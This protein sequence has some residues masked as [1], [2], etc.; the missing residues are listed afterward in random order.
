M[1]ADTDNAMTTEIFKSPSMDI[2]MTPSAEDQTPADLVITPSP[3]SAPWS[4]PHGEDGTTDTPHYHA[5]EDGPPR[6]GAQSQ[7]KYESKD[8]SQT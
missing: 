6:Y 8:E 3:T 7:L 1:E 5:D 2:G 4:L